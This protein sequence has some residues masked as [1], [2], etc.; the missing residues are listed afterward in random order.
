LG[1]VHPDVVRACD[2]AARV[3]RRMRKFRKA[4]NMHKKSLDI[5][6]RGMVGGHVDTAQALET[7]GHLHLELG[8]HDRGVE[9]FEE[10]DEAYTLAFGSHHPQYAPL[11]SMIAK[12]KLDAGDMIGA[13]ANARKSVAEFELSN[14][15][16]VEDKDFK[17]AVQVLKRMEEELDEG[18]RFEVEF[19]QD[20]RFMDIQTNF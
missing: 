16:E 11:L 12:A 2:S 10:A 15:H 13:Y 3:Y 7:I 14:Y 8:E 18:D 5:K 1:E 17:I 20:A 19:R 6:G 9:M 4:I